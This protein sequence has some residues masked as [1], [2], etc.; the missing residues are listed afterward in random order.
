MKRLVAAAGCAALAWAQ[1]APITETIRIESHVAVPM[2]D[3]VR[4]YADVYRPRREGRFPV[5]VTRTPYGVQR[6]GAHETLIKFAQRG[7]VAVMQDTRGR[8]ESEGEWYPFRE[9][10]DGY[11]TVEW[12]A[13]QPWSDGKVGMQGGSYLGNVQWRAAALAP[14]HLA[15]IFPALASTSLYH[16]T[17]FTGCAFRL[18]LALGWGVVRMPFRIMN[19]QYWHSEAYS[20]EELRYE[21]I[22]WTLPL[23]T[24]DQASSGQTV[25]HYRDWVKHQSYDDYWRAF[26][27]EERFE[28][29][30]VP[31]HT[32]GG[33]YDLLLGGTL[34]GFTGMRRGGGSERARRESKM[35]IGPWGHGATRKFGDVDFG[36]QAMHS[37]FDRQIRWFDHYLKGIDNGIER[38]PPVEIFFM[39]VNRWERFSDWP[40]PGA[41]YTP[42]YL[43]SG[44]HANT[45]R[46][47]GVLAASKPAG[48]ATDEYTYDP[49]QPV[50]SVGAHDCCGMPMST[51]PRDQRGVQSRNDVLVYTS[52]ILTRP[53][54]IAGPVAVK[55]HAATDGR[56][57]DFIAKLVDVDE[58]GVALNL[59]QGA[60]RARFRKGVDRMELL[61]PGRV[62]EFPIDLL[63]TAHV[64]L[65]GH[66]I[67]LAVTSSDF[68]QFDRNPNTGEDLGASS[69]LRVARQTIHHT[70]ERPSQ[71]ILPVVDL[72]DPG[73]SRVP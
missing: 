37:L 17:F 33:W 59:A 26:S 20:P 45:L 68:P 27:D 24:A 28:N 65:P 19:P 53:L 56:D 4:L 21:N 5:I 1:Q 72:S 38:D 36:E 10:N 25:R 51:G 7:Y 12:A 60:L 14:P 64:F 30:N 73:P 63:G 58:R 42:Y 32:Y 18:S 69:R 2:R 22:E 34:N 61:E 47:D 9:G 70:A 35:M 52:S 13:R 71:L 46:G 57:T 15:A 66:R 41:R 49:A 8:F 67:R 16:N 43:A 44:G 39:G 11:D 40:P 29:V 23:Q 54:A 50:P 31:A 6:E 62:Y 48:A 3:G 55:L